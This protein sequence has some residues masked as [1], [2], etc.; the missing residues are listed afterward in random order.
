[1]HATFA[2]SGSTA[3][4]GVP[5]DPSLCLGMPGV[6]Q[7]GTGEDRTPRDGMTFLHGDALQNFEH[8]LSKP[9]FPASNVAN[10]HSG[11]DLNQS[12]GFKD[13]SAVGSFI[14]DP[15]P[16][17]GHDEGCRNKMKNLFTCE[18]GKR[19]YSVDSLGNTDL[20][21]SSKRPKI[22]SNLPV[23]TEKFQNK[24]PLLFKDVEKPFTALGISI[25]AEPE[26]PADLDLSLHL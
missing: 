23:E 21:K 22:V 7:F 4:T 5:L 17:L 10:P 8:N 14:M 25:N 16:C 2:P 6:R 19:Q 1:M 24:E 3:A 18:E 20:V 26:V 15:Y 11:L 12:P 13:T 9:S